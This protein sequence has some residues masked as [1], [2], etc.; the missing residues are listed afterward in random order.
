V[1]NAF[2][3]AICHGN[4]FPSGQTICSS[5]SVIILTNASVSISQDNSDFSLFKSGYNLFN[6]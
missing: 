2:P 3:S 6:S 1:S 4:L 5:K